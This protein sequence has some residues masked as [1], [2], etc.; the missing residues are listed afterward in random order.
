MQKHRDLTLRRIEQFG[1]EQGLKGRLYPDRTPVKMAVFHAPGRIPYAEAV[2]GDYQP[3][4]VGEQFG[5][6]WSTHWVRIEIEIP[7]QWAGREVHFLWDSNSE[8]CIWQNGQP[9]QGLTGSSSGWDAFAIRKEYCLA[10]STAGGE[11]IQLYVEVACNGLFGAPPPF[12]LSPVGLIIQSEIAAFDRAAW[13]LLWDFRIV[14]DMAA[15]LPANTA[16]GAQALFTANEMVNAIRLDDRATWPAARETA[17]K[18]LSAHNGDGQFNLSAI[19][20][21]HIDTAWLWPLAETRRKCIRTF[22]SALRYMEEYPD[23]KFACSQAQQY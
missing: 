9:Q 14:A 13:D 2:Q 5:P 8:G 21:A 10:K 17:R 15:Q 6:A 18:F 7:R 12:M 1:S 23:Y 22:S 19:G 16:R 11:S 4:Q 20:H 3:C